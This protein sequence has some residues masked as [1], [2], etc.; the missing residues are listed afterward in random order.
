MYFDRHD[1]SRVL[2]RTLADL[3]HLELLARH[4]V[5]NLQGPMV[6]SLYAAI[7]DVAIAAQRAGG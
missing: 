3:I 2:D 7:D 5:W 6:G 4:V 1:T